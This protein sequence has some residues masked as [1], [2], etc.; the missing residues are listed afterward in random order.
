MSYTT[1]KWLIDNNAPKYIVLLS[2]LN[3][4][5]ILFGYQLCATIFSL[6]ITNVTGTQIVTVP[7]RILTL[8]LAVFLIFVS[9][10]S[11]K[12]STIAN[13]LWLYWLIII[14]RLIIDFYLQSSFYI[15]PE[16]KTRVVFYVFCITLPSVIAYYKTW[17]KVDYNKALQWSVVALIIIAVFNL[18]FNKSMLNDTVIG[19]ISGGL[20]LNTIAF[21][22][23]GTSLALIAVY[24]ILFRKDVHKYIFW[25]ILLLGV[26]IMLRA[27]SRGPVFTF[28]IILVLLLSMKTKKMF[29]VLLGLIVFSLLIYLF[30]DALLD[31]IEN[32]SF[33]LYK[34]IINTI[35]NGDLSGRD[36]I[37]TKVINS[38][39]ENPLIG[40]QFTYYYKNYPVYS[41]NIVLDAALQGGILGVMILLSFFFTVFKAQY[42]SSIYNKK[43]TWL[44]ILSLQNYIG[45][46]SSGSFYQNSILSVG[47]LA[48][49]LLGLNTRTNL[50]SNQNR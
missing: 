6:F 8:G 48:I 5:L 32:I 20:A 34:R 39:L 35:E 22:Q 3:L 1:G 38:W 45:S 29:F 40:S 47:V 33:T 2:T 41:H 43:M 36:V 46:L 16:G 24:F 11:Y 23:C 18:L 31:I 28:L 12:K 37:Y 17:D 49:S 50:L 30:Q 9:R 7:Y 19:R 13:L 44:V 25:A 14:A 15:N 4:V 26:F 27:G 21:G 10:F 42:Y